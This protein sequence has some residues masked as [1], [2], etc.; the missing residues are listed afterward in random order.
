ML[1]LLLLLYYFLALLLLFAYYCCCYCIAIVVVIVI[2]AIR[3]RCIEYKL[4]GIHL[5]LRACK[6][7][8]DIELH[9]YIVFSAKLPRLECCSIHM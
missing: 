6:L 3:N 1:L 5:S 8:T 7:L 4:F 2:I 9:L